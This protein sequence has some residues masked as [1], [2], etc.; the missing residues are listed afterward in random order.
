MQHIFHAKY[1]TILNANRYKV[2]FWEN[3]ENLLYLNVAVRRKLPHKIF[4]I[5]SGSDLISIRLCH[6]LLHVHLSRDL[7]TFHCNILTFF[8]SYKKT[9]DVFSHTKGAH[10]NQNFKVPSYFSK[11][12]FS[13]NNSNNTFC[14]YNV[15]LWYFPTL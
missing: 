8:W 13:K 3:P 2:R 12:H 1:T 10:K 5:F 6:V 14:V 15:Y 7:Q 11:N 4:W 9:L